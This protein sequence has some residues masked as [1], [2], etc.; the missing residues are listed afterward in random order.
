MRKL[1]E[2]HRLLLGLIA[3]SGGS[4][5]PD[6]ELDPSRQRLLDELVKMKRLTV[7]AN[8]GAPPRY[9]L[10]AQGRSDAQ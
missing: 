10:T 1:T 9:S 7:E 6:I 5:C 8:D 2:Y 4:Y 3:E